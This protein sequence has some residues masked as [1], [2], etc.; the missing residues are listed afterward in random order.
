METSLQK[1]IAAIVGIMILFI[2]PVYIAFEKV[3]D[4]SYSLVLKVTQNFVDN[5]RDKGYISPEM[6]SDFVSGLYSTNN[7]YDINI[8]HVKKRY[9]PA[10]Y[11]YDFK[12][13]KK[14]K[15]LHVLD[16]DKY[17]TDTG[18]LPI[19]VTL[20]V[21][22]YN[23][24]NSNIEVQTASIT[25]AN[26]RQID[27]TNGGA[28]ILTPEQLY[29]LKI[30]EY[31]A[32]NRIILDKG[33]IYAD[34]NKVRGTRFDKQI[35]IPS[36]ITLNAGIITILNKQGIEPDTIDYN[37]YI[38][39]YD[40]AVR[41]R[42]DTFDGPSYSNSN[43]KI[44][45]VPASMKIKGKTS[46]DTEANRLY[47]EWID[48]Y[49]EE[50]ETGD[51]RLVFEQGE[52]YADRNKVRMQGGAI[53]TKLD[54]VS[55]ISKVAGTIGINPNKQIQGYETTLD[56]NE[57]IS[58]YDN[59]QDMVAYEGEIYTDENS[60]I[61]VTRAAMWVNGKEYS[62]LTD[63]EKDDAEQLYKD[64]IYDTTYL[65]DNAIVFDK[66]EIYSE[67]EA[68]I[69]YN[70]L[71]DN[72]RKMSV[73]GSIK[74]KN[75][76]GFD[77][78][79][80]NFE[81]YIQELRGT[82]KI[83][84]ETGNT[85]ING[86]NGV[87]I[88]H[89]PGVIM[90]NY[91]GDTFDYTTYIDS[92]L[93]DSISEISVE[94]K[95]EYTADDI[96]IYNGCRINLKNRLTGK[97]VYKYKGATSGYV[98]DS[99]KEVHD[100]LEQ[101]NSVTISGV[102]YS[103]DEYE[104]KVAEPF[105]M[106]LED[107]ETSAYFIFDSSEIDAL[108]NEYYENGVIIRTPSNK[109]YPKEDLS[110][111]C[112]TLVIKKD[113]KEIYRFNEDQ[114]RV[115]YNQYLT[116]YKNANSITLEEKVFTADEL[117][118]SYTLNIEGKG[119]ITIDDSNKHYIDDYYNNK[120]V[121]I[122]EANIASG[123]QIKVIHPKIEIYQKGTRNVIY[124]FRANEESESSNYVKYLNEY[125]SQK[126]ITIE[127]ARIYKPEDVTVIRAKLV[128]Q[129]EDTSKY[130]TLTYEDNHSKYK[131]YANQYET[132]G[133][134]KLAEPE[135]YNINSDIELQDAHIAITPT[136][137]HSPM[138]DIYEKDNTGLYDTYKSQYLNS[139]SVTLKY[140]ISDVSVYRANITIQKL[141]ENDDGSYTNETTQIISDNTDLN[142]DG[143]YEYIGFK[144]EYISKGL[145]TFAGAKQYT[146]AQ[147]KVQDP[148]VTVRDPNNGEV[149]ARYGAN[150][151]ELDDDERYFIY[152]QR[153]EEYGENAQIVNRKVTYRSGD[154]CVIEKAHVM[155][156]E[157]I[158]DK[159]IVSKL[160]KD[161]GVSK[162]EFLRQCMLGNGDMYNS[163][164]YMNE[165][166]YIMN[167]GDQ[168]NVT[169]RNK[170]R[171]IASVF[172]SLFT[173]NIGNEDIPKVY[174]DYGGTIKNN[175]STVLTEATGI[176]DS[177]TGR[178]FKYRGQAEEVTLAPGRYQIECWGAAGGGKETGSTST[179]GGKGAYTKAV[180]N[181]TK[182]T[183]L[184]V[185]VGGKGSKY[186]DSNEDN[187]GYNGGGNAYN[188]YGGGGATDVR[189]L[190][191]NCD[192]ELSLLTRIIVAGGGGRK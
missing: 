186:S 91:T 147:L 21:G 122:K 19:E 6:Y 70:K 144:N 176:V 69:G 99:Y 181:I 120:R 152:N 114:D 163:L 47:Y 166:S 183:T 79:Y 109:Q 142:S 156:E 2:I 106:V 5:V 50:Q 189:L 119:N 44:S 180:F 80:F 9:D 26:G 100:E 121:V 30:D 125:N 13:E 110:V 37:S 157:H 108:M 174:V 116:E 178:L 63:A 31:R 165:N 89:N 155:N 83:V 74:V 78:K 117:D 38:S 175:G 76:T 36:Y 130:N 52:I 129:P 146:A 94:R 112:G 14:G 98:I 141:K 104:I 60:D 11:I 49:R 153:V 16:C 161:T 68:S 139:G 87:E 148:S 42:L 4:V 84:Y 33:E 67:S 29:K 131:D 151:D 10:I 185:Y 55:N 171:T 75:P 45:Y 7:V 93:D 167:E 137:Y 179:T 154:N 57:Y 143:T 118:V 73:T 136:G 32:L 1:I 134:V 85:Y 128:I 65:S 188:A 173:A 187:G 170:N 71:T 15:L 138:I 191:G 132:T 59:N 18:D 103:K 58:N 113:G 40:R 164:S 124:T 86:Q 169:V 56:Y 8:E 95:I 53:D 158:T 107:T 27:F 77:P 115:R 23:Q 133:K 20:D 105:Y 12:D 64:K 35:Y 25:K 82:D 41:N 54:I 22:I 28:T 51:G 177:E 90:D 3:D 168:I 92:Y 184:Y 101:N 162:T 126:S 145:I 135:V 123:V 102:T 97:A 61:K 72:I 48:R 81:K 96:W 150:Y 182:E 88:E 66:G 111:E 149:I 62:E 17:L 24:T 160:F 159:Q 39:N 172:Y 34:V 127:P 190:R 46:T 140:K 192:D 43:S